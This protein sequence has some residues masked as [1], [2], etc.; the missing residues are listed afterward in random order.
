MNGSFPFKALANLKSLETLDISD[1]KFSGNISLKE[2]EAEVSMLS[3]VIEGTHNVE[4]CLVGHI[5]SN[6]PPSEIVLKECMFRLHVCNVPFN[7]RS[8][9]SIKMIVGASKRVVELKEEDLLSIGGVVREYQ[10]FNLTS[11][12]TIHA[13]SKK[14]FFTSYTLGDYDVVKMGNDNLSEV[15]GKRDVCLMM[16]TST[17]L[18]LRDV[19]HIPYMQQ[20]LISICRLDD[21][22]FCNSFMNGKWKQTKGSLVVARGIKHSKL[23]VIPAKL[24]N[25]VINIVEN[26]NIAKLRHKKSLTSIERQ[27]AKKLK[28]IPTKL[29]RTIEDAVFIE[30]QTIEDAS[31]VQ[32][33]ISKSNDDSID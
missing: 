22:G 30:D 15:D 16:E 19:R 28:C 3:D 7:H 14:E 21:E 17:R 6:K 12:A 29:V 24:F 13:T 23:Y 5:L 8:R 9:E 31:K 25:D 1:N 20:N 27:I 11:G 10:S 26:D 33:A 4:C 18:V 32:K 2:D